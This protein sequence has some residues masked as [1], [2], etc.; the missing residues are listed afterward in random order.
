MVPLLKFYSCMY[1][2]YLTRVFYEYDL[3]HWDI[4]T[5]V[6]AAV[7]YTI[8]CLW[9]SAIVIISIYGQ[10]HLIS[11]NKTASDCMYQLLPKLRS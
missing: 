6:E 3:S 9:W 5:I 11:S 2:G 10:P 8:G 7:L 1:C 4:L